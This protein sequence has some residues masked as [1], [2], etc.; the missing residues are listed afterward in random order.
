MRSR[1]SGLLIRLTPGNRERR[2]CSA[3]SA[4]LFCR[5]VAFHVCSRLVPRAFFRASMESLV[6]ALRAASLMSLHRKE[7]C[8]VMS[9]SYSLS[10]MHLK[11]IFVTDNTSTSLILIPGFLFFVLNFYCLECLLLHS[12]NTL[13]QNWMFQGKL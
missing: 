4:L 10:G 2:R 6:K 7:R 8:Y 12:F 11:C 3:L 9:I 5:R 1:S 13:N